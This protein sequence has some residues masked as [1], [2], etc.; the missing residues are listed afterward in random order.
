MFE[1]QPVS[2]GKVYVEEKIA[3]A[4]SAYT[5]ASTDSQ[6]GSLAYEL[7]RLN[8]NLYTRDKNDT[9]LRDTY[10]RWY[11][12]AL[13]RNNPD[14]NYT[15]YK[16]IQ[17]HLLQTPGSNSSE[18]LSALQS[19]DYPLTAEHAADRLYL[20]G[21][22]DLHGRSNWALFQHVEKS[23]C[24]DTYTDDPIQHAVLDKLKANSYT[25]TPSLG[26]TFKTRALETGEGNSAYCFASAIKNRHNPDVYAHID[27]L[28]NIGLRPTKEN[29]TFLYS[30]AAMDKQKKAAAEC[31]QRL[32]PY[33]VQHTQML[34]IFGLSQLQIDNENIRNRNQ[35]ESTLKIYSSQKFGQT[36]RDAAQEVTDL[37]ARPLRVS[38]VETLH[39]NLLTHLH[40]CCAHA[41][42][43]HY[44]DLSPHRHLKAA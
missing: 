27:L 2:H 28:N 32:S 8:Y 9:P 26:M 34:F 3:Q 25:L 16:T 20:A 5:Q 41:Q 35:L 44:T 1:M 18:I 43:K 31:L 17:K 15:A 37:H 29:E 14:A 19:A 10:L 12:T 24:A 42:L 13:A 11:L 38:V 4:E 21:C 33:H 22:E 30:L 23:L 39:N 36:F 6:R 40:A 7:H